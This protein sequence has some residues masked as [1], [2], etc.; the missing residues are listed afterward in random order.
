VVGL[1][2][3]LMSGSYLD[4]VGNIPQLVMVSSAVKEE[5]EYEG[6][7]REIPELW[8]DLGGYQPF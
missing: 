1:A 2:T 6:T 4:E 8:F 5:R 7:S 3:D